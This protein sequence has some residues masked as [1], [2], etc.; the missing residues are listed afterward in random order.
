MKPTTRRITVSHKGRSLQARIRQR[1]SRSDVNSLWKVEL[2]SVSDETL[3]LKKNETMI[4]PEANITPPCA[5]K[6]DLVYLARR[7]ERPQYYFVI[8]PPKTIAPS[9]VLSV[10]SI[11]SGNITSTIVDA[12]RFPTF[13]QELLCK[14]QF[15]SN[16]QLEQFLMSWEFKLVDRII[17]TDS[18]MW[19]R[20]IKQ[21]T[22]KWPPKA[23]AKLMSVLE[24][25]VEAKSE[26]SASSPAES[27][28][29]TLAA[30]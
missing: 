22:V 5:V 19:G 21:R 17:A 14:C 10:G 7:R 28:T 23:K 24:E 3:Y 2:V 18:R 26:A 15:L 6:G 27:Q 16:V 1:Y 30:E 11:E 29:P 12:I 13:D 4:V 8:T 9:S 25:I 20:I